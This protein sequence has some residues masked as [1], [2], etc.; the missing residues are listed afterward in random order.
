MAPIVAAFAICSNM[1]IV[2]RPSNCTALHD[3]MWPCTPR[4]SSRRAISP[5]PDHSIE[6]MQ[7]LANATCFGSPTR[8]AGLCLDPVA[9]RMN[10]RRGL[11]LLVWGARRGTD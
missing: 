11:R 7:R 1:L 9:N 3:G 4:P 2:L 10:H 6:G 5:E 8:L